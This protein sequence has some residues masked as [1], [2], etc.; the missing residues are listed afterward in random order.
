[1]MSLSTIVFSGHAW[2][3]PAIGF[4]LILAGALVWAGHRS[5]TDKWVRVGCLVLKATGILALALCLVEPLWVSQRPVP[6]ANFFAVI[7]DNSQGLQIKDS[8][9]AESRGEL[10]RRELTGDPKAW[11]LAL[12]ENFQVRRYTFDS[13]LQSTRDFSELDF[14]GRASAIGHAL[15]TGAGHWHG[16]PVA[17][18]LLFTDGNATDIPGE[19]PDLEGCP[20]VYP[21]VAGGDL[22][23]RDLSLRKVA[24]SQTAFEDAPVM[25]QADVSAHGFNG[26]E[27]VARLTEIAVTSTHSNQPGF[28]TA[29]GS[30]EGP[31]S[32]TDLE[33]VDQWTD[34]TA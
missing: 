31:P 16:Q 28:R 10:L 12:E 13:R 22:D 20:P 1:M 8:G 9:A 2:I 34:A 24:V 25:I 21:V 4:F 3:L 18:V 6:G 17:G 23:I 11:R 5:A 27:V 19:L 30:I 29:T 33:V 26:A 7:A 15:R 14:S 32:F